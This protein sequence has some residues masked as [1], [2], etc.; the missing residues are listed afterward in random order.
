[1]RLG[2]RIGTLGLSPGLP[3]YTYSKGYAFN[4]MNFAGLV[5]G[6]TR[7]LYLVFFSH[8]PAFP[9]YLI[10][11]TLPV[12]GCITMMVSISVRRHIFTVYFSF[13]VFPVLLFLIARY[14]HDRGIIA[15]YIPY[16]IYPFFFLNRKWKVVTSFIYSTFF[17]IESFVVAIIHNPMAA[18]QT[19]NLPLEAISLTGSVVLSFITLYSIKFQVWH[20]QKKILRQKQEL[21]TMNRQIRSEKEK[22]KDS[23]RVKDKLFSI[24]SHDLRVPI[25]G[26]HL[27][28]SDEMN[29]ETGLAIL[30]EN[31][32]LLKTE[33]KKTSRLFDDL[34]EWAK[35]QIS[36]ST[37]APEKIDVARLARKVE[38]TLHSHAAEKGVQV[39]L[40]IK[41]GWLYADKDMM[42]IVLRNLVSNAI[43]F[44]PGDGSV[45]ISGRLEQNTYLLQVEDNGMGMNATILEKILDREFYTS[46]GTANE[47]G[48]GLGLP[49]CQDLVEKCQGQLSIQSTAGKG[50]KVTVALPHQPFE[51]QAEQRPIA[52]P[53][54]QNQI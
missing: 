31:L 28:L 3:T 20:Y 15:Y 52:R 36:D 50:T 4:Q 8:L 32:P 34:L 39:S 6:L 45:C 49:I 13:L 1:M 5:I 42:E 21:E 47:M 2:H 16:L 54:V 9:G 29:P 30:S 51:K 27:L 10:V 53:E 35:L 11:N 25:Q 23:N 44:T 41:D 22:L 14:V 18:G 48:T 46:Y 17:F 37:A 7:L 33:L 19:Y 43:K 26:L 12:L 24:I 38:E 40:A